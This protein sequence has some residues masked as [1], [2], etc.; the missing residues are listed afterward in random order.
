M[1]TVFVLLLL[2][3]PPNG[4][5]R[6]AFDKER[7]STLQECLDRSESRGAML[8]GK[9]LWFTSNCVAVPKNPEEVAS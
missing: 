3:I 7:F 1:N 6:I 5:L 8:K 9:V 2:I 4:E